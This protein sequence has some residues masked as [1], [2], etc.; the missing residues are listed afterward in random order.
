MAE[1]AVALFKCF[2]EQGNPNGLCFCVHTY[3]IV[4]RIIAPV[5]NSHAGS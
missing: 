1:E 3:S 4:Y 2:Y 5:W